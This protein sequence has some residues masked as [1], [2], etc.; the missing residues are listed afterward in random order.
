M[1][2]DKKVSFTSEEEHAGGADCCCNAKES[3]TCC[4]CSSLPA[5]YDS[6]RTLVG[7]DEH[8]PTDPTKA[9]ATCISCSCTDC[10]CKALLPPKLLQLTK[11]PRSVCLRIGLPAS[12]ITS[13]NSPFLPS[14]I[15][16]EQAQARCAF[17]RQCALGD[18][19]RTLAIEVE[20]V[21]GVTVSEEVVEPDPEAIYMDV[22]FKGAFSP[23]LAVRC[24][25]VLLRKGYRSVEVIEATK[26]VDDKRRT[27]DSFFS[28]KKR[29]SA[30]PDTPLQYK[31]TVTIHGMTCASCV[32]TLES[33]LKT[34]EGVEPESV[35]VT[36]LPQQRAV[37]KHDPTKLTAQQI[38]ERID[39]TGFE[40]LDT[41]SEPI[42]ATI[43]SSDPDAPIEIISNTPEP[44]SVTS[45]L[46]VGGMTCASCSSSV[47]SAIG[48]L[49]GVH[50]ILVNLITGIATIKHD[51]AVIGTRDLIS[52]IEDV[53]FTSGLA[54][55]TT[56]DSL[57]K[58]REKAE[59]RR[60]KRHFFFSLLFAIPIFLFSM[61]LMMFLPEHNV[62]RM[63]VMQEV[64]MGLTYEALFAWIL[65]TPV[66]FWLGWRFYRG[67]WKSLRYTKSANMD[68]LVALG[69]SAA[70]FYS[71]YAVIFGII[72]HTH[73]YV[74]FETSVFLIT[75]I[76]LGKY[77]EA[78]AKGKTSEA[79]TRLMELTPTT[80]TLLT[81]SPTDP[82]EAIKEEEVDI[83]LVQVGD[84]LKV[85][86]GGRMPCDGVIVKGNTFVDES[87]LTGEAIPV[88][89]EVGDEV[90]GGTVNLRGVVWVKG[91]K[92]GSETAL[93]RIIRMVEDAQT[94]RA[95]IQAVADRISRFFVP[96][97]ILLSLITLAVWSGLVFTDV[98]PHDWIPHNKPK[99]AFVL[100][101]AIAVLVIACPCSLG[102]ATPTAVMVGTGVAA[103][104]GVLVKGGGAALEMAH[105][106]TSIAFDK[107]G[108]L[109]HGK[110]SVVDSHIA[111]SSYGPVK[112][113]H[114]LWD[115]IHKIE[116]ASDHPLAKAVAS[117]AEEMRREGGG[118][119][120]S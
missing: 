35:V 76:L 103:R 37:L 84:V 52:H 49:P 22:H 82:N 86:V 114:D 53:G 70:Y 38:A 91:L 41:D 33:Q 55:T 105:S 27:V 17:G 19:G 95:P 4:G 90:M 112:S 74:F 25:D 111:T 7:V 80:A 59:L 68:V 67:S 66:Q 20:L 83:Q 109:T 88:K 64:T 43:K 72:T 29:I 99:V 32:V 85:N 21:R 92:V 100:D 18:V 104:Y 113:E 3:G 26:F 119:G 62:A 30:L 44:T 42:K 61:V 13:P 116:G 23:D 16:D 108:T 115:L 78:Y 14:N 102:L 1:T 5:S 58:S 94:S 89:K 56:L 51:P 8:L 57:T 71:V 36:L 10:H 73:S 12:A 31:T 63:W 101:F 118:K 47:E 69:T 6:N 110:P 50:S 24:R 60:N 28:Y 107:T 65:A 87:M 77:L 2:V 117:Y 81:L 48:A 97:I 11:S 106:V 15:T 93:S 45:K 98:V 79:I 9:C 34:L 54:P 75:F 120:V 39:D 46:L 40:V 96:L